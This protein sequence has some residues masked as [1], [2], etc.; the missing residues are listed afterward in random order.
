MVD[1]KTKERLLPAAINKVANSDI[2]TI[3]YADFVEKFSSTLPEQLRY[4]IL[5]SIILIH[6]S[7]L[8]FVEG[9]SLA[10]ENAIK[11]AFDW[12]VRKNLKEG[13]GEKGTKVSNS[14]FVGQKN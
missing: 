10:V 5:K 14:L 3:E 8:F 6:R 2:Y 9:G 4:A 12:K 1:A 7:H 13:K 11:T